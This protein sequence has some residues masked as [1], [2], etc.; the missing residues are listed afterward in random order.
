MMARFT[1]MRTRDTGQTQEEGRKT[2]Q[3]LAKSRRYRSISARAGH[4]SRMRL[5][6]QVCRTKH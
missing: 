5:T 3:R 4:W 6:Q 1:S 2:K